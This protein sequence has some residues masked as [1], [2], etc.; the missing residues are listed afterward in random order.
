MNWNDE[1][2][3]LIEVWLKYRGFAAAALAGGD[4]RLGSKKRRNPGGCG[5][6][7]RLAAGVQSEK[8]CNEAWM[9]GSTELASSR[10]MLQ[11]NQRMRRA[12]AARSWRREP[13]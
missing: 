9:E 1:L 13:M 3:P 12:S 2:L 5:V 4:V 11:L 6:L 7:D 10:A 8:Y